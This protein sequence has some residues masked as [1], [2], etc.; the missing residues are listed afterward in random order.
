MV[1]YQD[2]QRVRAPPE[3]RR[4]SRDAHASADVRVQKRPLLRP[5]IPSPYTGSDQQKVVYVSAKTPFVSAVKRVRKLLVEIDKRSMGK[6]D[7]LNGRGSEKQKLR[8]LGE[9]AAPPTGR[10]SEEV[11]LKAT[12]RAIEKVLELALYF[13]GQEDC[14][15]RLKTGTLGAVDDLVVSDPA[16]GVNNAEADDEEDELPE[17]R[18]RKVT[19]VEVAITLK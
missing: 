14:N 19:F 6:V 4:W 17:S 2:C 3:V 5:S 1:N 8:T 9:K 13:Q 10:A 18:V 15:M 7:L 12:N 16:E 11:L